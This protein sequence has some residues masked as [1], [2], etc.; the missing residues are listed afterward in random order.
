MINHFTGNHH[1]TQKLGLYNTFQNLDL[2]SNI[3]LDVFFPKSYNL[4]RLK[5]INEFHEDFRVTKAES[6]LKKFIEKTNF[7]HIEKV[8]VAMHINEKRL[9]RTACK[10]ITENE[11]THIKNDKLTAAQR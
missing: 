3:P 5:E 1:I 6:I 8:I 9:S 2:Y 10:L 11:W 4:T 7:V